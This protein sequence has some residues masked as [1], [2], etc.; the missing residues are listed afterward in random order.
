MSTNYYR[1]REPFTGASFVDYGNLV[2]AVIRINGKY[3]GY[4]WIEPGDRRVLSIA[5]ADRDHSAMQSHSSSPGRGTVVMENVAGLE[6]T[7]QL[8]DDYGDLYTVA[9][10]RARDG[11]KRVDGL[12]CELFGYEDQKRPLEPEPGRPH[13]IKGET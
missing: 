10:I 9:Q 13:S 4:L 7:D 11:A 12:P 8:V 5:M 1:L 3:A 2:K 6:P